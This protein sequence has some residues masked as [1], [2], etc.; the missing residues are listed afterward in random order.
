MDEPTN[1]IDVGAK[2]EIYH[3]M[4]E[5]ASEGAAILFISSYMPELMGICDRILVMRDG[6]IVG[7]VSRE[8]MTEEKLLTLAIKEKNGE[9]SVNE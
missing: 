3:L 8:E 7:D 4:N 9:V 6:K 5:L 2:E 1:G